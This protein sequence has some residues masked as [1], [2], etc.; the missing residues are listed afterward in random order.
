MRGFLI[1]T[2]LR[3]GHR[4]L[5]RGHRR[6]YS[7]QRSEHV[8]RGRSRV[9]EPERRRTVGLQ[10]D[11]RRGHRVLR[12]LVAKRKGSSFSPIGCTVA[13]WKPM[14]RF[15]FV[16]PTRAP[17]RSAPRIPRAG[18]G[19]DLEVCGLRRL[20]SWTARRDSVMSCREPS[21]AAMAGHA[22]SWRSIA[23]GRR[24]PLDGRRPP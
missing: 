17:R 24:L 11:R 2:F 13:P 19:C 16:R 10:H 18:I 22:A 9:V 15:K 6:R 4:G 1:L 12:L 14:R 8:L 23:A 20:A 21:G 3:P 7:R 5:Y